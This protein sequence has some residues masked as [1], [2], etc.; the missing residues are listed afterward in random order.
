MATIRLGRYEAEDGDMPDV[1]MRCGEPATVIKRYRFVWHPFWCYLLIPM[2][3]LIYVILA[4]VLTQQARI[5]V[6]LCDR[7]KRHWLVRTLAVW[8]TFL[9]LL[10]IWPAAFAMTSALIRPGSSSNVLGFLCIGSLVSL[11]AWLISIPIIQWTAIHPTEIT[12]RTV[13][14]TRVC[15][16]YVDALA[17]HRARRREEEDDEDYRRT[18]RPRRGREDSEEVY[19]PEPRR[20]GRS[21]RTEYEEET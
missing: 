4:A 12:E 1:C 10:I 21:R 19:D 13:T 18:F 2:G 20:R 7:H 3:L 11:V 16:D 15:P 9:S 6:F 17:D 8:G 14:L 5:H